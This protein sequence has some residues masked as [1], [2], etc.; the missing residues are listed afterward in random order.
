MEE[1]L[2]QAI[3]KKPVESEGHDQ[4][5]EEVEDDSPQHSDHKEVIL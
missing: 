4:S 2:A 5:D 1:D 3:R